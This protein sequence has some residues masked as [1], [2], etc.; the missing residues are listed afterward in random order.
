[1]IDLAISI[2]PPKRAERTA[3]LALAKRLTA[4]G[5]T[6][7][8][9]A[10]I[11][12]RERRALADTLDGRLPGS[13]MLVA[14]DGRKRVLG[15]VQCETHED[16]FTGETHGHVGI[17][18][19]ARAAEGKGV[20]RALLHAAEEWAR[21]QGYRWL[22]LSVFVDNLRAKEFYSRQGWHAEIETHFKTLSGSGE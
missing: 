19:V 5:P 6:T 13:A 15:V 16:Y 9:V 10:E 8:S 21:A 1:V 7:R 22:T 18:A 20:G 14:R 2:G 17:L 3:I 4:F 12:T 11:V